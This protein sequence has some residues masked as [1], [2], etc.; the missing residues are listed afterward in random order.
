LSIVIVIA[1]V[2]GADLC[3]SSRFDAEE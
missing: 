2:E 1:S 3:R